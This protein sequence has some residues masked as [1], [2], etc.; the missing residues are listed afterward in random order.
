MYDEPMTG[1]S[2]KEPG[3]GA[4]VERVH[5]IDKELNTLEK[6][7]EK[8]NTIANDLDIGLMPILRSLP[9]KKGEDAPPELMPEHKTEVG[10]RINK[11]RRNLESALATLAS[12][13]DRKEI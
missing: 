12:I 6:V 8:V 13:L 2:N 10:S 11:S 1:S 3:Y 9:N 7:V 4:T 5:E